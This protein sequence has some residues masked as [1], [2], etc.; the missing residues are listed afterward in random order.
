MFPLKEILRH[1]NYGFFFF[2]S[3]LFKVFLLFIDNFSKINHISLTDIACICKFKT[4]LQKQYFFNIYCFICLRGSYRKQVSH[5][6]NGW[7]GMHC[8]MIGV[9]IRRSHHLWCYLKPLLLLRRPI[10]DAPRLA[11]CWMLL[12]KI[13]YGGRR[14]EG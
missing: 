14:K 6:A 1:L 12:V 5:T 11:D 10:L 2:F 7:Q 4:R 13:K 9:K 8:K 3:V